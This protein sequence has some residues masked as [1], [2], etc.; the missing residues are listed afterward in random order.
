MR[1]IKRGPINKTV[2]TIKALLVAIIIGTAVFTAWASLITVKSINTLTRLADQAA[3]LQK[4]KNDNVQ[5]RDFYAKTV[6]QLAKAK[7]SIPPDLTHVYNEITAVIAKHNVDIMSTAQAL[8]DSEGSR[9]PRL[10]MTLRGDYYDIIR[11]FAE[12]RELPFVIWISNAQFKNTPIADRK[13]IITEFE[14]RIACEMNTS[15]E[16]G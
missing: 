10:I 12:W 14:V 8:G 5:I 11:V 3:K 2:F 13:V 6:E 4:Q 16:E 7:P 15:I 1:R 9:E